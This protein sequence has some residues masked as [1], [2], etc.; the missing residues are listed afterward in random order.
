MRVVILHI[1]LQKPFAFR[2]SIGLSKRPRDLLGFVVF[3]FDDEL[4]LSAECI[5]GHTLI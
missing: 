2:A 3:K 1:V 5:S 4:P